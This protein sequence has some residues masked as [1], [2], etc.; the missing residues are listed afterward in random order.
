LELDFAVAPCSEQPP[1]PLRLVCY[2]ILKN[3]T[4]KPSTQAAKEVAFRPC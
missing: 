3:D 2:Q 1:R 4:K